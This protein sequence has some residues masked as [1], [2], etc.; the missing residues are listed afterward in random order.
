M[1]AKLRFLLTP[2][3]LP[4]LLLLGTCVPVNRDF[5]A[6]PGGIPLYVVSN[7]FH[8]DL[9]FPLRE[10]RSGTDWLV[11]LENNDWQARFRGY[12]Y[13][14]LGWGNEGF[15]LDSYDHRF[16]GVGTTLKAIFWPGP[17]LMHVNFYQRAPR[18][19]AR[20]AA[21]QVNAEQY[22]RLVRYVQ[23]SFARDS[24]GRLAMRNPAGYTPEDFFFRARG[25]YHALR[26]CNDWTNQALKQAG[27]RAAW[28]APLAHSVMH[29]ARRA[30]ESR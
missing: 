4:L 5:R 6:T 17:T 1:P 11:F 10:P 20:V 25:R 23:A 22:G 12:E 13:V 14:A 16:P 7:G 21:L 8:T 15:Y 28:K 30:A 26:T 24:T 19:G 3:L 18:P 2:V 27:I 29:Q 9:L